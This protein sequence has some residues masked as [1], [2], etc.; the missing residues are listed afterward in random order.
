M[1]AWSIK[2]YSVEQINFRTGFEGGEELRDCQG[3]VVCRY[4]EISSLKR[5]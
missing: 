4:K 1:S 3:R 2:D 5:C